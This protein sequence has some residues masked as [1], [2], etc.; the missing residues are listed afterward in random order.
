[1]TAVTTD[2]DTDGNVVPGSPDLSRRK[3]FAMCSLGVLGA[4]GL[5]ACSSSDSTSATGTTEPAAAATSADAGATTGGDAVSL[6][7]LADVPVAGAVGL[8]V[9]GK[10]VIVSQPTEGEVVGF[11]AVCPHQ[12]ATVAVSGKELRCPLHGSTFDMATGKNLSGPAAGKPLPPYA[13]KVVDG[14]VVQA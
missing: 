6:V 9:A 2:Q 4:A 12:F 10:P 13:V 5:A 1:M 7:K 8:E 14:E 11:S 3:M